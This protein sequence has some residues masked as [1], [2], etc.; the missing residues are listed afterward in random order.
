MLVE[1][2]MQTKLPNLVWS[3]LISY[4]HEKIPYQKFKII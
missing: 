4:N 2:D 3:Q 1:S